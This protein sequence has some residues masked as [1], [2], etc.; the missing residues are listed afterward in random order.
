MSLGTPALSK[1]VESLAELG[2]DRRCAVFTGVSSGSTSLK[3]LLTGNR[4]VKEHF[5]P[6]WILNNGSTSSTQTK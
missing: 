1:L 5:A 6:E 2:P 3:L 4:L